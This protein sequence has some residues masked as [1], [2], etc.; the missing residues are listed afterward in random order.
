[1]IRSLCGDPWLARKS[2]GAEMMSASLPNFGILSGPNNPNRHQ[3]K[4]ADP[5]NLQLRSSTFYSILFPSLRLQHFRPF[6]D[7]HWLGPISSTPLSDRG[8]LRGRQRGQGRLGA[9]F[10]ASSARPLGTSTSWVYSWLIG[11]NH[12]GSRL[13][14]V[15]GRRRYPLPQTRTAPYGAGMHYDPLISKLCH[16]SLVS[17]G[18]DSILGACLIIVRPFPAPTKVFALPIAV[19]LST[20]TYKDSPR[21]RRVAAKPPRRIPTT[22]LGPNWP[23]NSSSWWPT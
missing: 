19:G 12:S 22:A 11:R 6:S 8:H 20:A 21:E 18:H 2:R 14:V 9:D 7:H 13:H 15:L 10:I 3:G 1:M 23:S 16:K 17:W 4:E 5:W